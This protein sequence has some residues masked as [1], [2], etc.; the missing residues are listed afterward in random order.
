M[1]ASAAVVQPAPAQTARALASAAPADLSQTP[2][3]GI[4]GVI[5][6]AGIVTLTGRM[7][8]LGLADLK[9]SGLLAA[10]G[11]AV[12]LIGARIR[13]QAYKLTLI[14]GFYLV[15]W[16]CAVALLL[17]ALLHKA[18]LNY[19]ELSAVQPPATGHHEEVKS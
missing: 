5:M 7:L 6:G 2:L 13:L 17:V 3:L 12:E 4:L 18:P 1:A 9:G 15:G 8:T 19:G 14:D 16:A 10:T 11:R